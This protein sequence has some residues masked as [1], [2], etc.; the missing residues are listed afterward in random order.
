M[1]RSPSTPLNYTHPVGPYSDSLPITSLP[2][3]LCQ[4]WIEIVILHLNMTIITT[5]QTEDAGKPYDQFILFGDSITQMSYNQDNGFGFGAQLQ[6]GMSTVSLMYCIANSTSLCSETGCDQPGFL[7]N[8]NHNH[9]S[10]HAD[11]VQRIHDCPRYQSFPEVFSS[12]ADRQCSAYGRTRAP[13][14]SSVHQPCRQSSSVPTMHASRIMYNMSPWINSRIILR[15]SSNIPRLEP[16]IHEFS[17]SPRPPSTSTNWKGLTM[18]MTT[19]IPVARP[20]LPRCMQK[21]LVKSLLR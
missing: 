2:L 14:R 4:D 7:V 17:S 1:P 21:A 11:K 5:P 16:T 10:D 9:S 13:G 20:D 8:I 15:K 12:A 18:T 19:L 3:P 6:E